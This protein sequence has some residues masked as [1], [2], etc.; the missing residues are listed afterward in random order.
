MDGARSY[1]AS[2]AASVMDLPGLRMQ[3][4]V[5][6]VNFVKS[7]ATRQHRFNVDSNFLSYPVP[8]FLV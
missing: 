1:D 2:T 6:T 4:A 5:C 7:F 3:R 8:L